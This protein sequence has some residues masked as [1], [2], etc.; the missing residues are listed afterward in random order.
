MNDKEAVDP[1]HRREELAV[2]KREELVSYMEKHGIKP[3][4]ESVVQQVCN[5]QPDQPFEVMARLLSPLASG[6]E[7]AGGKDFVDRIIDAVKSRPEM[8]T[9]PFGTG[10]SFD[11]RSEVY[12]E[13]HHS[14]AYEST[15]A[16]GDRTKLQVV[17]SYQSTQEGKRT[18]EGTQEGERLVP[19]RTLHE[20]SQQFEEWGFKTWDGSQVNS[21]QNWIGQWCEKAQA[22][23][24]V[25][26]V[27]L[28]ST[29][30]FNSQACY[31]E[32]FYVMAD[33][34]LNSRALPVICN[35]ESLTALKTG[36]GILD[37]KRWHEYKF[38]LNTKNYVHPLDGWVKKMKEGA[39]SILDASKVLWPDPKTATTL[40]TLEEKLSDRWSSAL[41]EIKREWEPYGKG[42]LCFGVIGSTN[43]AFSVGDNGEED[44]GERAKKLVSEL[45]KQLARLE[46]KKDLGNDGTITQVLVLVTG[47]FTGFGAEMAHAFDAERKKMH[48]ES[49][50]EEQRPAS[51]YQFLPEG[52]TPGEGSEETEKEFRKFTTKDKVAPLKVIRKG[53]E[54]G[55]TV[56]WPN[57]DLDVD[58]QGPGESFEEIDKTLAKKYGI[59]WKEKEEVVCRFG[60]WKIGKTKFVGMDNAERQRFLALA[61][62][63]MIMFEG[64]PGASNEARLSMARQRFVIPVGYLGGGA[65]SIG[66]VVQKAAWLNVKGQNVLKERFAVLQLGSEAGVA[67]AEAAQSALTAGMSVEAATAAGV[68]AGDAV[69][70]GKSPDEANALA[71]AAVEASAVMAEAATKTPAGRKRKLGACTH[72]SKPE[73]VAAA[74][75]EMLKNLPETTNSLHGVH[76]LDSGVDLHKVNEAT[77]LTKLEELQEKCKEVKET[78]E[79]ELLNCPRENESAD[80]TPSPA[81]QNFKLQRPQLDKKYGSMKAV[82][83][84]GADTLHLERWREPIVSDADMQNLAKYIKDHEGQAVLIDG[85][86]RTNQFFKMDLDTMKVVLKPVVEHLNETL[87]KNKK[88]EG[89]PEWL[90]IYG[91]DPNEFND[92]EPEKSVSDTGFLMHVLATEFRV[93]IV[94]TQC[95]IYADAFFDEEG[96]LSRKYSHLKGG[97]ALLYKTTIK[98]DDA[99]MK[100]PEF[101]GYDREGNLVGASRLWFS[102]VIRDYVKY[103]LAVGG[104]PIAQ[105]NINQCLFGNN[106]NADDPDLDGRIPVLYVP[107]RVRNCGAGRESGSW[108]GQV[109]DWMQQPRVKRLIAE[110]SI[111][112]PFIELR[113]AGEGRRGKR[114]A[115][116]ALRQKAIKEAENEATA[117][118]AE[119]EAT[120]GLTKT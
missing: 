84:S 10:K 37:E 1:V 52:P 80:S 61:L 91:G 40:S 20:V 56:W 92:E 100:E 59:D 103:E 2:R 27:F 55:N 62:P 5:K 57:V 106:Q 11:T 75:C 109:N 34:T 110:D 15:N 74:L 32:F 99:Q 18:Q 28:L 86:G 66:E 58:E 45:A 50:G 78:T 76:Y 54:E 65:Q 7:V 21:G 97:A 72:P 35:P 38:K 25:L 105:H 95:D 13:A 117:K 14:E 120:P 88:K 43:H 4:L 98:L 33:A 30:F 19:E 16:D 23:N 60:E 6:I 81:L 24:T 111:F 83:A 69:M 17:V 85:H 119:N 36:E 115:A 70:R 87:N 114:T 77:G 22:A 102:N 42:V 31:D 63:V 108:F 79:F 3:K 8:P 71:S 46:I 112:Q 41:E 64:G 12:S 94:A 96:G 51:V 82:K 67:A 104:G 101:G 49:S 39:M 113:P 68:A 47:G 29:E 93:R 107:W 118:E 89:P 44:H 90:A 53:G 73:E 48:A 9:P 116:E 26:I